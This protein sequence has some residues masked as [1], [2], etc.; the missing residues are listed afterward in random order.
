[1]SPPV[2]FCSF[3]HQIKAK[4]P[5][6]E[7]SKMMIIHK[8]IIIVWFLHFRLI[9]QPYYRLLTC[10]GLHH[11][12]CLLT[13]K[14]SNHNFVS[15]SV[16]FAAFDLKCLLTDTVLHW[17]TDAGSFCLTLLNSCAL[18]PHKSQFDSC[19]TL[20][21][22]EITGLLLTECESSSSDVDGCLSGSRVHDCTSLWSLVE[23]LLWHN[24]SCLCSRKENE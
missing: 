3:P 9:V 8:K 19:F 7:H 24:T 12:L 11:E 23:K 18:P 1:M 5:K 2:P 16:T 21:A 4:R 13:S 20:V 10:N 15:S 22:A 14:S 17:P 6:N